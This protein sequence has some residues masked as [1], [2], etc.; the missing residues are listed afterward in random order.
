MLVEQKRILP[1]LFFCH[2]VI[3]KMLKA[4]VVKETRAHPPKTHNLTLLLSKTSLQFPLTDEA[5]LGVLMVYQLE[6]RYPACYPNEPS[7]VEVD[8]IF[9]KTKTLLS[10]LIELL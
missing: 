5:F 10:W 6:G 8:T 4:H 3:E 2:L 7:Q 1:G 9:D